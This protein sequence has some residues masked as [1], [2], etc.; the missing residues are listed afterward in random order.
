MDTSAIISILQ[1]SLF[2]IIVFVGF[3]VY[4]IVKGRQALIN[5][6]MGFYFALL[7]SLKFPYYEAILGTSRGAKSEALLTI[8][9]FLVFTTLSTILFTRLMPREYAETAFE[10]FGKKFLLALAGTVLVMAFSYHALPVTE[11]VDP[12]S[13]MQ[14]LFAP[15]QWFF[16]WLI[17]PIALL[18]LL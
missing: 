14:H 18:F 8:F 7:L 10:T 4:S 3:L 2:V 9:V 16:W 1:E 15:E 6:I 13:P 12:G 11:F 5:L 17:A